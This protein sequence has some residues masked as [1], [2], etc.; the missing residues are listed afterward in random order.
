[1]GQNFFGLIS[2]DLW[3]H[4]H[5]YVS[6]LRIC[7]IIKF[8]HVKFWCCRKN[9]VEV[10]DVQKSSREHYIRFINLKKYLEPSIFGHYQVYEMV[11]HYYG[12]VRVCMIGYIIKVFSSLLGWVVFAWM[13]YCMHGRYSINNACVVYC[14]QWVQILLCFLVSS[15]VFN[16]L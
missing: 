9:F 3:C 14:M 7:C 11:Q 5:V 15:F 13:W 8:S 12:V 4:A 10:A 1:M 2:S 6:Y 16:R